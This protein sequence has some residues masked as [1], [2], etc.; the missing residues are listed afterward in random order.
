LII[1][2]GTMWFATGLRG[3][4]LGYIQLLAWMITAILITIVVSI[5]AATDRKNQEPTQP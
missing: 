5:Q 1:V 2:A 4:T 3:E